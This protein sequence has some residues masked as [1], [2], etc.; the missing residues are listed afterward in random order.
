M[1]KFGTPVGTLI[2]ARNAKNDAAAK[3]AEAKV[4]AEIEALRADV[5]KISADSTDPALKGQLDAAAAEIA[6]AK[7]LKFLDGVTKTEDLQGVFTPLIT[8]WILPLAQ[9]CHLQ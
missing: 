4:K 8:G 1:V 9:A 5:A 6:K 2:A 7:D 3:D